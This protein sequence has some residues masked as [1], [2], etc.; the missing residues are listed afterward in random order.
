MEKAARERRRMALEKRAAEK[1]QE[2]LREGKI[3]PRMLRHTPDTHHP[4]QHEDEEAPAGTDEEEGTSQTHVLPPSP[5]R[6]TTGS[7]PCT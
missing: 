1:R 6:L 2:Q 7:S 4:A 5:T 3:T